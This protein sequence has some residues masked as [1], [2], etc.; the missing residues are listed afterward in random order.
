MKKNI[1][2][3]ILLVLVIGLGAYLVNVEFIN[4][5][6]CPTNTEKK[7]ETKV[8]EVTAD[9]RY[10]NY[11][12]NLVS[13]HGSL[14]KSFTIGKGTDNSGYEYYL[15][16][17]N[18][19]YVKYEDSMVNSTKV[20]IPGTVDTEGVKLNMDKVADIFSITGYES[21]AFDMLFAVMMDGNV[22]VV[23]TA[24]DSIEDILSTEFK[25]ELVSSLKN[26]VSFNSVS[27]CVDGSC[28]FDYEI[29]DIEGNSKI[30]SD[31]E[32]LMDIFHKRL[33]TE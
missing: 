12:S 5:K 7:E 1:L 4:K 20:V 21:L 10:K 23:A 17:D 3:V 26:V 16:S 11:L 24:S 19:L 29:V 6:E 14:F 18:Y 31:Y 22:Y 9:E 27:S 13:S 33:A 28:W 15:G 25:P 30:F 32:D 8:Q 2:I